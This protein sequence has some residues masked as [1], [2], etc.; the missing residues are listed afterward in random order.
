VVK[1]FEGGWITL[2]ITGV[3]ATLMLVIKRSYEA[4]DRQIKLM[5]KLVDEVEAS[6]PVPDI[7]VLASAPFDPNSKTAVILVKDF[8]A[9]GIKT[10]KHIFP[11]FLTDFKNFVF[12]QVGLIDAGAFKGTE[13]LDRVKKKVENELGRYV[14]LLRRHGYHAEGIALYGIDTAE[15]LEKYVPQL[16]ER[17][18]HATFFGGQLDFP[19]RA[20]LPRLLHNYT[21]FS[22]Q[23]QLY[24]KLG[25]HLYVLPIE[26]TTAA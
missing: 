24:D 8:S 26:L 14:H 23:R 15:E 20:I 12:V 17:Y 11:S 13:E 9:V 7:P 21:L 5:E 18:P 25:V 10:I 19:R 1:F 3:L 22:V 6:Q 4:T 2:L 16:L